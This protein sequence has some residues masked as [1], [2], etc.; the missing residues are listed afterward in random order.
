YYIAAVNIEQTFAEVIEAGKK[1]VLRRIDGD[2]S[3]PPFPGIVLTDTFNMTQERKLID[4]NSKRAKRQRDKKI[5]VIIGNPPYS[6]GQRSQNDNNQNTRYPELDKRIE[7]T[8]T[9]AS[10][11]TLSR[12]T[13]DSYIRA[14]RWASDRIGDKGIICFVSNGS[15]IDGNAMD[16]FRKCLAEEF[17]DIYCFN[18]RGNQRTQGEISRKE[19]GKIFGSGSRTPV[20][21]TLL[22]KNPDKGKGQ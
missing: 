8:Y 20:A 3:Y 15:Y 21:I 14:F 12:Y 11:A 4:E 6:A 22:V 16:G 2:S 10:T 7:E 9:A 5:R 18:L 1:A 13:Y 17:T 19:G